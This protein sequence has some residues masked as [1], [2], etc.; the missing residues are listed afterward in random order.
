MRERG[1]E[2]ERAADFD[3]TKQHSLQDADTLSMRF[4]S[5]LALPLAS[6]NPAPSLRVVPCRSI[7]ETYIPL[8]PG[9]TRDYHTDGWK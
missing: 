1:A 9:P 7:G 2:G 8:I 4:N 3:A 5:A 6:S